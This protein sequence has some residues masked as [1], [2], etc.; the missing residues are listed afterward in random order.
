MGTVALG[1]FLLAREGWLAFVPAHPWLQLARGGSLAMGTVAFFSALFQMPLAVAV[2][3][4]FF[5]PAL[6]ALLSGPLLGEKVKRSTWLAVG[7]AFVG[8][9]IVLRPNVLALGWAAILPLIT[10][11]GMAL[12][13]ITNRAAA[14]KG[15][16]SSLSMQF[17]V[18]AGAAL[19]LVIA[20]PIGAMSGIELFA[21]DWPHWSVVARCFLVT[22]T[23]TTGHWLIYMGTTKAGA[24]SISPTTY[25]QLIVASA[26]GWLV[27]GDVPDL[28]TLLGASIIIAAGLLLWW[29]GRTLASMQQR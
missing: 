26:L 14:R 29:R 25:V 18:A 2:S 4:A 13:V 19:F 21:M 23:G 17:F 9:L 3:I 20:A 27:F 8:V 15:K 22:I 1:S 10:A 11:L 7:M 12:L 6:A 16:G 5:A 28:A 24:S